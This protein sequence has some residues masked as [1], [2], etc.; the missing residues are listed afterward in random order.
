MEYI[1]VKEEEVVEDTKGLTLIDA[2]NGFDEYPC[3]AML[4]A[5]RHRWTLVSI[6]ALNCYYHEAILIVRRTEALCH[7]IT[8]RY[9][10]TKGYP[11]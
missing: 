4:W 9:G 5:V 7:I 1:E 3:L 6:F 8:I 10:V 11:L 2:T